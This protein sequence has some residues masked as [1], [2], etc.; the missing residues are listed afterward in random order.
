MTNFSNDYFSQLQTRCGD[1]DDFRVRTLSIGTTVKVVSLDSMCDDKM[2]VEF[3]VKPLLALGN[4]TAQQVDGCT[5]ATQVVRCANFSQVV[6]NYL[7][8]YTLIFADGTPSCI[9]VDTFVAM[10]RTI[11]EPPTS[12][13]M[14]GPREGFVESIKVNLMLMCIAN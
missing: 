6:S 10:G 14:R 7:A 12:T 4:A 13:V 2:V 1:D 11:T 9:A 8:G 3:V 5:F